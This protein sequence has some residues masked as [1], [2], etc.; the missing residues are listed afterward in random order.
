MVLHIIATD[1]LIAIVMTCFATI[2]EGMEVL[3]DSLHATLCR[4]SW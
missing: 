1:A 4:Q 3:V 2:R